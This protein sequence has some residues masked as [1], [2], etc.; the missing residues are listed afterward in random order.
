M[1]WLNLYARL[2]KSKVLNVSESGFLEEKFI[3]KIC[4]ELETLGIIAP[5]AFPAHQLF[6]LFLEMSWSRE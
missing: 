5:G 6:L 1:P 3:Y 2:W 4:C